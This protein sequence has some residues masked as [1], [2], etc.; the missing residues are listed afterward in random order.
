MFLTGY[1][2]IIAYFAVGVKCAQYLSPLKGAKI[3]YLYAIVSLIL[4]SFFSQRV[5]LLVM[6]L[7]G[8]ALVLINLIGIFFLRDQI[9][10]PFQRE[11]IEKQVVID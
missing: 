3:Y 6:S 4:F 11:K 1:S 9:K 5:P 10:A 7:S 2:T 8:G